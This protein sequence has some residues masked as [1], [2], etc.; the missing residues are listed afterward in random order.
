MVNMTS[1]NRNVES[2]VGYLLKFI[3]ILYISL[4]Y[5]VTGVS[6]LVGWS[7]MFG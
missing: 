2:N 1:R 7:G 6:V 3:L 5:G 4:Y